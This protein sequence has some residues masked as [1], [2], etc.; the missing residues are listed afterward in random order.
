[1][2]EPGLTFGI[3]AEAY[4]RARPDWPAELLDALPLPPGAEVADVGAGTGKLTRVLAR[5]YARV[6]A[7][8]PDPGMRALIE[9]EALDGTAERLPLADACV[10][11]VFAAEAF[12][13]FEPAAALS[14][15]GRVLRPGGIVALLW[16]RWNRD[17]YVLPEGVLPRSRTP[18]HRL[19]STGEWRLV[20]D[21]APFEP[22]RQ[23]EVPRERDVPR[24]ELLDYFASVSPVTWLPEAERRAVLG[25]IAAALDRPVY[26]RRWTAVLHWTRRA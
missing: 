23:V 24:E 20:F 4:E 15:F 1:V 26:R 5:R 14:E 22:L 13:W 19:F 8:E 12:H 10:D 7:V 18:K 6:A 3:A 17:D 25:R 2:D 9:G 16:N 21:G 11:A